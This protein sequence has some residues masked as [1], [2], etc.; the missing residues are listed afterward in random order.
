MNCFKC[1]T[2]VPEGSYFCTSCGTLLKENEFKNT[3]FAKAYE[4]KLISLINELK[5][6][7]HTEILWNHTVD[8]YV[9]VVEQLKVI[10]QTPEFFKSGDRTLISRLNAFIERCK[11][12]EFH[13][14]FV[15]TIKA[16]KST[17]INALLGR[18]LASTSV[19]PETAVLTKFR[20]CD[21]S[22]YVKVKFYTDV[23]WDQ[24]WNSISKNA[25]VFMDEYKNLNGESKKV[26]WINH[27]EYFKTIAN[28][29][30]EDEIEKWTSSKKVEHYFVKEVEV[31][32]NDF[33]IPNQVVFVDTPGLDDAVRYR[34]DV[35]RNYIDRAN[36]VFACIKSDA[37]TG[38][39]LNT[40]YRIFSNTSYNPEKVYIIGTQWDSMNDPIEDWK[41]Q[42]AEWTKYLSR[43]DCFGTPE[44]AS[45]NVT[46]VAA[47]INN[48]AREYPSISSKDLKTL[49]SAAF[50]FD[51]M[52]NELEENIGKLMETSNV[53]TIERKIRM[54][55]VSKYSEL[56][57][58]DIHQTYMDIKKDIQKYFGEI[59]Q[60]QMDILE[61]SNKSIE[62]IR[63]RYDY[64]K[65]EIDK[66]NEY[67]EQLSATLELVREDTNKRVHSLCMQLRKMV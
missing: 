25:D 31:G 5:N 53:S 42:K 7:Q 62:E 35:T 32:I 51:I 9:K 11:T 2:E 52:P 38:P 10:I 20:H 34:S 26:N 66:I 3:E 46:Y 47:H 65:K 37:L 23:E 24:L 17:L 60:N 18:N 58:Q 8:K 49:R 45:R 59:K 63:S 19:T 56:L 28:E 12:P 1:Q 36:A 21:N 54:D 64:A 15:G 40:L 13:I 4:S 16:G 55:I 50:K 30:L 48:L 14:A 43:K 57:Y 44:I 61:T 27:D 41:E 67:K 29:E 6:Y 39:E 33:K 22:N